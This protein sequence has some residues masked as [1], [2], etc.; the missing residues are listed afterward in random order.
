MRSA[1]RFRKSVNMRPFR[2]SSTESRLLK[3]WMRTSSFPSGVGPID[4]TKVMVNRLHETRGKLFGHI[5]VPTTLST[6]AA[7]GTRMSRV[8]KLAS[9]TL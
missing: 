8:T 7:Q 9:P 1:E 2:V 4:A 3:T 6:H 5:A